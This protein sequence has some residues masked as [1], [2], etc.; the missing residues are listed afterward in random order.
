MLNYW[1][2]LF[3]FNNECNS[4][5]GFTRSLKTKHL[6]FPPLQWLANHSCIYLSDLP[7]LLPRSESIWLQINLSMKL[8]RW[9][10]SRDGSPCFTT[11]QNGFKNT[12]NEKEGNFLYTF[13]Q[14]Q[15]RKKWKQTIR[16]MVNRTLCF[17]P[18]DMLKGTYKKYTIFL[19]AIKETVEL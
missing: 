5:N 6:L 15:K 4:C 7:F 3:F 1:N 12:Y 10:C 17:F 11:P 19:V 8:L 2:T 9:A 14:P 18:W 13:K 16:G